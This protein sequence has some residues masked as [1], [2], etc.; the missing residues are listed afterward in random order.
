MTSHF[1]A[2]GFTD[3]QISFYIEIFNAFFC[4]FLLVSAVRNFELLLPA[5]L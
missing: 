1:K 2:D 3:E 5:A 4:K